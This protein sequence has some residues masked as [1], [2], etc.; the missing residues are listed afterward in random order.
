VATTPQCPSATFRASWSG[1][2]SGR[3]S[4]TLALEFTILT[5]A[6]SGEVTGA[7]WSEIDRDKAVWTIPGSRMKGGREHRVPLSL[8]ALAI[9]DKLHAAR[10]GD[11]V[12]PGLKRGKALS[13]SAMKHV[14]AR[15]KVD[16]TT[17][18]FRSAFRD[19]AAEMTSFPHE[20]CEAA[21]AHAISN[22]TEAAYRRGDLFEKRRQLMDAWSAFCEPGE[23]GTVVAFPAGANPRYLGA[24]Q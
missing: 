11:H 14:L 17:H 22:K 13:R 6:R 23:R 8:R 10:E 3:R 15:M 7:L 1:S 2:A 16:A 4:R 19:W 18:G 9:L 5:D 24:P 21:L 12:F 20:V